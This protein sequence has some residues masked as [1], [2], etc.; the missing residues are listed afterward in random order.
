MSTVDTRDLDSTRWSMFFFCDWRYQL[1]SAML[2]K[3]SSKVGSPRWMRWH[4]GRICR[5][6]RRRWSPVRFLELSAALA[7]LDLEAADVV[8]VFQEG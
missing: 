6:C 4:C 3:W 7:A 8:G 2:S 1:M 5:R